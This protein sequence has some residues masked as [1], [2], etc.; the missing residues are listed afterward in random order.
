MFD[1]QQESA[2][3]VRAAKMECGQLAGKSI[4]VTGATGLVG[5]GCAR[6]LLEANRAYDL[7]IKIV[8]LV[9]NREKAES[10]FAG[11]SSDDGLRYVLGD[12]MSADLDGIDVDFVI[13]AACPTASRYFSE[14]PVDTADAIVLGTKAMLDLAREKHVESFIYV[15]SMEVYGDGNA[16]RGLEH[17]LTEDK[18]GYVNPLSVRSCYPEGKRMAEQY[19][20]AY[21]QQYSV[22]AKV[23]RLAQTFGPGIPK[24]DVRVFAQFARCAM[25]GEDIVLKTTGASTR[26]YLYTTDAV[27][28]IF[29]VLLKGQGGKAYN[30]ANESTYSSILEMAQMV[31]AMNEEGDVRVRIEV[32]PDAPYPPEHHLPL[33]VD[34]LKA[35]GWTACVD[36]PEMYRRLIAFLSE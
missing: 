24:D 13:H 16:E 2:E 35:L 1:L 33:A 28:A 29:A 15:S 4:L 10:M 31:A 8:A 25:R 12:L 21:A 6:F 23:I 22:P 11:Y 17:P 27:L 30:A 36:L 26:M 34:R 3:L 7:G 5:C 9:R 32:D 20:C 19:C 14:H 18:V